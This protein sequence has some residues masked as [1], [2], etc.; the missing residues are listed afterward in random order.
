MGVWKIFWHILIAIASLC[1]LIF[2]M[3]SLITLHIFL[4]ICLLFY[5]YNKKKFDV[6]LKVL[7]IASPSWAVNKLYLFYYVGKPCRK[8]E[9]L[10][11]STFPKHVLTNKKRINIE[12]KTHVTWKTWYVS[13]TLFFCDLLCGIK[14][15]CERSINS[16]PKYVR[17]SHDSTKRIIKGVKQKRVATTVSFRKKVATISK[18]IMR[19]F[20]AGKANERT[21]FHPCIHLYAHEG[22]G[23]QKKNSFVKSIFT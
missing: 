9:C 6:Q 1:V 14:V 10:F 23:R 5:Y 21:R 13:L 12:N 18:N 15:G 20:R 3:C 2:K 8:V 11:W 19:E 7:T 22:R 4:R 17:L 16:L